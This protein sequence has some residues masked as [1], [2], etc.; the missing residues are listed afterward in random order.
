MARLASPLDTMHELYDVVVVGSGYGG[1]IAASRL[2]RAGKR[3]CVLE[4]GRE[5]QPGEFPDTFAEAVA[6]TQIDLEGGRVGSPTALF[7][8]RTNEDVNVL[9]GCGLGGTSLINANVVL[10]AH[11]DVMRDPTWPQ[12][13]RDDLETR[14]AEGYRRARAM[15]KP[16]RYPEHFPP[17]QKYQALERSA[18]HM[19]EQAY[20]VPIAVTFERPE[21]GINHVGVEQEACVLCGDCV[22]GCNHQAKN[23]VQMTYLPDAWNHGAEIFTEVGVR[24][25]E[26]QANRWLVHFKPLQVGRELF[27]APELSVAADMVVL[28]AGALGSTEILLRSRERGLPLSNRV[29]QPFSG[30][31]DVIAFAYNADVPVNGVGWGVRAPDP[32]EPVGPCITGIIDTRTSAGALREGM[33]IEEGSMPGPLASLLPAMLSGLAPLLGSDTDR[34][35]G[36]HFR[37]RGREIAALLHGAYHGA[38]RHTQTFLVMTHDS[39]RGRLVLEND[40]LKVIWP[41]AGREDI[42]R[43]VQGRI[44]EATEGI[45]GTYLGNPLCTRAFGHDL[46]TVHPL[47]GCRMG[48]DAERGVVNHK[49]QVFTGTEGTEVHE[50]LYI[51]D[52]SVIPTSLG[53]NPLLTICATAER[54]MMLIAEERG[55]HFDT[56][57]PSRPRR[58]AI[59]ERP[60]LRFT[61]T[62][63]GTLALE[64]GE[65]EATPFRFTLTIISDDLEGMLSDTRHAARLFGTVDA[66]ALSSEPITVR[67]GVFTLFE[68]EAGIPGARRMSYRMRLVTQAGERYFFLGHKR[69]HD[70]AGLDTWADTTTL[71]ITVHAGDDADGKVIG[72]GT[73]RIRPVDFARQ[74]TTMQVTGAPNRRQRLALLARFG[75]LFAG[76]LLDTYGGI[77]AG[78]SD[79]GASSEPRKRRPLQA[80]EPEVHD[81]RAEDGVTIR[82]TRYRGGGRGPVLLLHGLGVSSRIFSIDTI[83]PNLLETLVEYGFDTWLLDGRTSIDLPASR[84]YSTGDEVARFDLPAAVATVQA[85]TGAPSIQVIGHCYGAATFTMS[86]LGGW[87]TGVRSAVLSQVA[88]HF[89]V[90]RL[91]S[92]KAGLH[93]PSVLRALGAKSLT[94]YA[95]EDPRWSDRAL[96]Q[97][98]RL[99]PKEAEERCKSPVCHRIT[100]LYGHLYEHDRLNSASHDALPEM[101]GVANLAAF[102]HL[103]RMIRKGHVLSARGKDVYLPNLER[104]AI[105]ITF[106]SGAENACFLPESTER[107]LLALEQANGAGLYH[108]ILIP[109]YG[110]IDCIFGADAHL[111]VFP[112]IIGHLADTA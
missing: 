80:P 92:S 104:M 26:R 22:S 17:L 52:G 96:D 66:P 48:E 74:M 54:A 25:V 30:N 45:G 63:I 18:A 69:L 90:P 15:L 51:A 101:F 36:D 100:F 77:F 107:S 31:G 56:A 44:R 11:P 34:G 70:D 27:N 47:G 59:E 60:G 23:T 78:R 93:L 82:L 98:L 67:D 65:D 58:A 62:M 50:G 20:K 37:E 110:H 87:L 53:A 94:A 6:A 68:V 89:V 49:G 103:T 10:E 13:F 61:E 73:L 97:L 28:A 83:E 14:V 108:R 85:T 111:D 95:G 12:A 1:G 57:L 43:K 99:Y 72:R 81:V 38:V 16:K 105:P 75:Q 79:L 4:R 84:G 8:F 88:T 46:I 32:R 21:G 2:A 24:S 42:I 29:G 76:T 33:S 19:G 35:A 55:W 5:Y 7:D 71:F 112:H 9:V 86:L 41:G 3:V 91:T 109:G 64:N 39:H 102:D 106:I 40:R